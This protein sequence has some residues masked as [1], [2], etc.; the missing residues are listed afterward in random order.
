MTR[1]D[2]GRSRT[3]A[4][5]LLEVAGPDLYRRNPFRVTG[6]PTDASAR[7]VRQRRQS[8]LNMLELG[9]GV[10]VRD[11]RLPLPE[12]P[13]PDEVRSAFEA[14][15]RTD[16]RLVDELFWWWGEPNG[17]GCDDSVHELHDLAVEAHAKA[18]DL[19]ADLRNGYRPEER[20]DQWVDAADSWIDALDADGFWDHVR[21]RLGAL[22]D[23]RLD[24]STVDGLRGVIH[25]ALIAPQVTLARRSKSADLVALLDAWDIDASVI[26]DARESAAEPVHESISRHMKAISEL[27]DGDRVVEAGKRALTE[28][29]VVAAQLEA[30]VPAERFRRSATTIEK[31]AVLMNN[32]AVRLETDQTRTGRDLKRKLLEQALAWAT[33]AGNRET[34]EQNLADDGGGSPDAALVKK[35]MDQVMSLARS[36]RLPDAVILLRRTRAAVTDP[37]ARATIDSVLRQLSPAVPA[38]GTWFTNL[39]LCTGLLA[40][41]VH[42]FAW[43]W[44]APVWTAAVATVVL[45]RLLLGLIY[46]PGYRE[47]PARFW[48]LGLIALVFA[49]VGAFPVAER[50]PETFWWCLG[51]FLVTLPFTAQLAK[52]KHGRAG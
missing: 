14:L 2:E 16:Q 48:P 36:G 44:E 31:L 41:V 25:R 28:L 24:E 4:N 43:R 49:V 1:L 6:L 10:T 47:S 29:P 15:G 46:A 35:T 5:R 7:Q 20:I 45:T 19:E 34:I 33:E 13:T 37:R 52:A 38:M 11:G 22:A 23:R 9:R 50:S 42:L 40:G 27:L 21:H 17:C 39:A 26:A 30:L 8:V 18:L 32:C 3:A 12:P 51:T